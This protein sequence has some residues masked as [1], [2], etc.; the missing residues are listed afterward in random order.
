MKGGQTLRA[1]SDL[2]RCSSVSSLLSPRVNQQDFFFLIAFLLLAAKSSG[3][4]KKKKANERK[5]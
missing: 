4:K 5:A 3:K 1:L 2:L